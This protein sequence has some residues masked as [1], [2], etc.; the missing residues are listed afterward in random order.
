M[1]TQSN[2]KP[3]EI[4]ESS[5][6]HYFFLVTITL[7]RRKAEVDTDDFGCCNGPPWITIRIAGNPL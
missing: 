7:S 3:Y 4:S 1:Y 5:G 6:T 2:L